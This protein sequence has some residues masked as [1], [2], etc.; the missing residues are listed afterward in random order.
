VTHKISVDGN[1][2]AYNPTPP[3]FLLAPSCLIYSRE[4]S[5]S[6]IR[7]QIHHLLMR[8]LPSLLRKV[9]VIRPVFKFRSLQMDILDIAKRRVSV[10]YVDNLR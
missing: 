2:P 1:R 5:R 4:K 3:S 10:M 9:Q 8:L 6:S 7:V